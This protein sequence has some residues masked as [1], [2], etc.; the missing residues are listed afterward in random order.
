L[1]VQRLEKHTICIILP[2]LNEESTIG[3]IIDEIPC[4]ALEKEGC[5]VEI[6]VVDNNSTDG[7]KQ[8]AQAKGA[9]V[10][11]EPRRGKG[12]AVR[13]ALASVDADCIFMLDA[14]YTYPATYTPD[15]L[16]ILRHGH[17][18][19]I[20]SR[21]RGR[22]EEGA[23]RLLNLIGN[24]LLSFMASVLYQRRI[25]DLC[26]GYW[27]IRGEVIR[28]LELE[29]DGFQ[30]ESELFTE[31]AKKGY[32]IADL[33]IYYRRREARTKL[34]PIRDG[35]KIGSMLIARRF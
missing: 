19:V 13:T 14:D 18:V 35:I 12:R 22:R 29:V 2:A 28:K 33:P 26:T 6:V 4:Q 20:G 8:V 9:R 7:T 5:Q 21:L 34:N 32:R 16:K 30:F 31:L 17:S 27:G 3:K 15:M 25:S 11:S 1:S 10:I 23:M 24:L